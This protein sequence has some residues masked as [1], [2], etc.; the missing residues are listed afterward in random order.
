MPIAVRPYRPEDREPIARL[1]LDSWRST[2]LPVA[3]H[4]TEA[5]NLDRIDRELAAGWDV[6][7]ACD[8]D[9]VVGFLALKLASACL[10]Q[11]FIAP[12]AQ[13]AGVGWA[14]L[15]FAKER[16]P[17]GFWLRTS[18]DNLRARRFY[19]RNGM[20]PG[21]IEPHPTFGHLTVIYRWP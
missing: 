18:A 12:T 2:G 3:D 17:G 8:E 16:L 5:G 21:E 1:W 20:R 19:E 9:R 10:D 11:L 15:D 4:V 7:L 13:G 14:L 6:H